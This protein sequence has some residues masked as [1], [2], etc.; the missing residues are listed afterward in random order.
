MRLAR[1]L[2]LLLVACSCIAA[3]QASIE[4]QRA[5]FL[6]AEKALAQGKQS[7]FE[8]L[9]SSLKDYPLLPYLEYQ[10]LR[11]DLRH[12]SPAQ[13]RKFLDH[14]ADTPLAG[15]LRSQWL[16]R[17]AG[18]QRWGTY[19]QFYLA[20]DDAET[21]CNHLHALIATG[22]R[23]EAFK[24]V[25]DLWLHGSSQP[26]ACDPV[27]DAWRAAGRLTSQL[28][29]GRIALAFKAGD[30]HLAQ[31]LKRYL[32]GTDEA[33][34]ELW[35]RVHR[36]PALVTRSPDLF[37]AEHPMRNAVLEH[38]LRRLGRQDPEG[39]LKAWQA[40]RHRFAFSQ[41]QSE[42]I[43]RWLALQLAR[44]QDPEAMS[45][46][47]AVQP[48]ADD[49][50]LAQARVRTA[51]AL[52]DWSRVLAWIDALPAQPRHESRWRY[53]RARA[54]EQ[55][56]Q[57]RQ[58]KPMYRSLAK[59]RSYYG[60]L[61]AD[62]LGLDYRMDDVPLAVDAAVAQD[63]QGRPALLRAHELLLLNRLAD[64]RREWRWAT[65]AMST[66]QLQAAAKLAQRWGWY[67][68]AIL[69]VARTGYW[70][71]LELR[72]PLEH[73]K[74]VEQLSQGAGLNPA[75]VYAVVRQE[76][77]FVHDARSSAGALG[78][79]QLMP[80]TA[81]QVARKLGEHPPAA[82]ALLEPRTNIRLGSS[83]LSGILDE[84]NDHPVLATAAYNAGP[85]RVRAWLPDASI[86]ADRWVELIPFRETRTYV[87]RVLAYTVIYEQRLGAKPS[88]LSERMHPVTGATTWAVGS[89]DAGK[90]RV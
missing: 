56:G 60:F 20:S 9:A 72:F 39:A 36:D 65:R 35:L 59:E 89:K 15:R 76:S 34:V 90:D 84:L 8:R 33:W 54:L 31:Y 11:D 87:Q 29:W 7:K 82:R 62:H 18:Q 1:A 80:A 41:T 22:H 86:E 85:G 14:Y 75:W 6:E 83:Y 70:D 64:A 48:D 23:A 16:D 26:K 81:K 21:R 13:V 17:L 27:F 63:V 69:T 12:A 46:L 88:R 74:L 49:L 30:W 61:A 73:R 47:E 38:G 53:W 71:D 68:R 37:S 78:L 58:A 28:T 2:V 44:S 42:R 4:T 51:L 24:Q 55:L 10:R 19:V 45:Y 57:A 5:R 66:E 25:P 43:T 3:A 40:L 52:G 67:D 50:V 79:M 32:S 77:A